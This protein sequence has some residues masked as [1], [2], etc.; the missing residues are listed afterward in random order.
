MGRRGCGSTI[1]AKGRSRDAAIVP[2]PGVLGTT[3]ETF[4][5]DGLSR[6]VSSTDDNGAPSTTETTEYVYD[7][8]GRILEDKQNTAVLSASFL[9]DGRRFAVT[10]PGG[11]RL[12]YAFDGIDRVSA[13]SEGGTPLAAFRWIG[14][15]Y[16][17]LERTHGNGTRL[18]HLD[19]AGAQAVGYDAAQ[20]VVGLRHVLDATGAPFVDRSYAYDRA[21]NRTAEERG[22]AGGLTDRFAYDSAYRLVETHYDED[23]LPGAP[24][25][26][27]LLS[28]SYELDGAGNRRR[29]DRATAST[30]TATETLSV[31][32][33]HEY[34]LHGGGAQTHDPNGNLTGDGAFTHRYDYKDRLA[35]VLRAA[36]GAPVATYAYAHDA[37]DR[38]MRK[39]DQTSS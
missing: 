10:Y 29:V 27:E 21:D 13:I 5:Y 9:G 24:P 36:D 32:E 2:G 28:A 20:R 3:L 33:V 1:R 11:R 38:R 25:R 31:N 18:T 8:L 12:D 26:R 34:T 16:R 6:L 4:A 19:D 30:G 35:A 23:G 22:E 17:L 15:G 37:R 39:T 7:S 14:P